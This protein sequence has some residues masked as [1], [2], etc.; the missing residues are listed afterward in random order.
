M[1]RLLG[2]CSPGRDLPVCMARPLRN[3]P[4]RQIQP[5]LI[6]DP[7]DL[8]GLDDLDDVNDVDDADDIDDLD[9]DL[10]V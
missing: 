5:L 8:E 9:R 2:P 6:D 10:S 7:D 1:A 3:T 4:H